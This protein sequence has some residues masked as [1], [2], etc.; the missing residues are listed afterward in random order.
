MVSP[1]AVPTNDQLQSRLEP[2]QRIPFVPDI[3]P[4]WCDFSVAATWSLCGRIIFILW[5][6]SNTLKSKFVLYKYNNKW[7]RVPVLVSV[8]KWKMPARHSVCDS[9]FPAATIL[10]LSG[11]FLLHQVFYPSAVDRH[12]IVFVSVTVTVVLR[13]NF[14]LRS[15]R[16][17]IARGEI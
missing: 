16:R 4:P 11:S 3:M 14:S 2:Y 17:E 8:P 12:L 15:F 10:L 5:L 9:P 7:V 6:C 1:D 13:S